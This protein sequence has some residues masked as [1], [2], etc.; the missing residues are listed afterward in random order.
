MSYS[1]IDLAIASV[2]RRIFYAEDFEFEEPHHKDKKYFILYKEGMEK[3]SMATFSLV[4]HNNTFIWVRTGIDGDLPTTRLINKRKMRT[5]NDL[6]DRYHFDF[7][8]GGV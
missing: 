3:C 1:I 6:I 5:G 4:R 8:E 7:E 2:V